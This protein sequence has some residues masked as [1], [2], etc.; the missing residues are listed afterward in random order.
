MMQQNT[1]NEVL[2]ACEREMQ[3]ITNGTPQKERKG[4]QDL[5]TNRND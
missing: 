3:K 5:L 1:D 4:R 2:K